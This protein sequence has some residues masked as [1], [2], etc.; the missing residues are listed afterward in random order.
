MLLS[1][2]EESNPMGIQ[3]SRAECVWLLMAA[4]QEESSYATANDVSAQQQAHQHAADVSKSVATSSS[5]G[6]HTS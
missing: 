1:L 5:R 3:A 2:P 4:S 6:R